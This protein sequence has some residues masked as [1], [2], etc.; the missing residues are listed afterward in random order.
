MLPGSIV[1]ETRLAF[2][3]LVARL[4][5]SVQAHGLVVIA[6]PSASRNAA[7]RGVQIPGNAMILAFNNDFAV[8]LLAASVAAGFE[9]PMRLYVTEEADRTAAVTYRLP[10]ALLAPYGVSELVPLGRELDQ[11]FAAIVAEAAGA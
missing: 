6:R 3:D 10:S 9:A 2:D 5:R 8:R 4:E 11:L 7:A 1:T